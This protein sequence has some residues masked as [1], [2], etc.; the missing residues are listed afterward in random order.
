MTFLAP[1]AATDFGKSAPADGTRNSL[2]YSGPPTNDA[3]DHAV[4]TYIN[5]LA[6][7]VEVE[8]FGSMTW[9]VAAA[10]TGT[11]TVGPAFRGTNDV[12]SINDASA[13]GSAAVT[14]P[15]S[16]SFA[17]SFVVQPGKTLT[18]KLSSGF[19]TL[20]GTGSTGTTFQWADMVLKYNA[21]KR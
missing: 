15:A 9:W 12:T 17:K 2:A 5:T 21:L 1:N 10:A 6:D 16:F 19:K 18:M 8:V 11:W 20:S 14:A 13:I 4:L 7:P 3:V